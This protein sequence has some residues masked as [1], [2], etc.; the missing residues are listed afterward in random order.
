MENKQK[1]YN[2]HCMFKNEPEVVNTL[3]KMRNGN[4]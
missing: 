4:K 2:D 3:D 1:V